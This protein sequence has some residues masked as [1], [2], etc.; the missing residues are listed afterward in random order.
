[1]LTHVPLVDEDHGRPP[2][3]LGIS[4]HVGVLRRRAVVRVEHHERDLAALDGLAGGD[5]G[6]LLSLV[7]RLAFAANAGGV[8]EQVAAAVAHDLRVDGVASRAGDGGNDGT[9][10][11]RESIEQRRLAHVRPSDDGHTDGRVDGLFLLIGKRRVGRKDLGNG[12]EKVVQPR[13]MFRG[14]R[15]QPLKAELVELV[16]GLLCVASVDLVDDDD[17]AGRLTPQVRGDVAVF[18][19]NAG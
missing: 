13:A 14:E 6:Q 8:D 1:M 15:Q 2:L 12:V 3:L 16:H 4:G 7:G 17:G 10:F 5:H 19:E 11:V 18:R 9:L